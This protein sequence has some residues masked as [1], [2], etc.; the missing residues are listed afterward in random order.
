MKNTITLILAGTL[1]LAC[2]GDSKDDA[3][4]NALEIDVVT[5]EDADVAAAE[6]MKDSDSANAEIDKMTKEFED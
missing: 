4:T 3:D 1:M 2:S 5:A 6:T